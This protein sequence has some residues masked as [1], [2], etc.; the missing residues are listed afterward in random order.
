LPFYKLLGL[1]ETDGDR[2]IKIREAVRAIIMQGEEILLLHTTTGGY[3]FPGGG[4]EAGETFSEALKREVSE[5]TG[6][7]GC[8]VI[9]KAG[10]I[11]ERRIDEYDDRYIFQ[12]NSHYFHC[13]LIDH[14]LEVQQLDSYEADLG[15]TPKWTG[16]EE[17]IEENNKAIQKMKNHSWLKRENAM[18]ERLRSMLIKH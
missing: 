13:D 9:E 6:Y 2:Q 16:I 4:V 8:R 15:F 1:S 17:A 3:K 5:E 11:I 12:M 14:T 7:T 18:L 10:E